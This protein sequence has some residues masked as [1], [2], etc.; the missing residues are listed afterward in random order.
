M[1]R[2]CRASS[3]TQILQQT[4]SIITAIGNV[5]H[6]R[7]IKE[8]PSS[9][10]TTPA[11]TAHHKWDARCLHVP[12]L[13]STQSGLTTCKCMLPMCHIERVSHTCFANKQY[14]TC[15]SIFWTCVVQRYGRTML[16][17]QMPRKMIL[18]LAP[19]LTDPAHSAQ[20]IA[21]QDSNSL[22]SLHTAT[23]HPH[24]CQTHWQG[25]FT[26]PPAQ[27]TSFCLPRRSCWPHGS[28]WAYNVTTTRIYTA[29]RTHLIMA[30]GVF[31]IIMLPMVS[32][33]SSWL[34]VSWC[35]KWPA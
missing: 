28:S 25:R 21:I 32:S 2:T 30:A 15:C 7:K 12:Q 26:A 9:T 3:C 19:S 8:G 31:I 6:L 23:K 18:Y 4:I 1:K 13:R 5:S 11:S 27:R 20:G 14:H 22:H 10:T 35:R 17:S 24:T 16:F 33:S 34:L 29:Q